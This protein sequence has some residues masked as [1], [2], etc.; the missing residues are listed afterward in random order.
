[1]RVNGNGN[2]NGYHK[3]N[4]S[5][6]HGVVTASEEQQRVDIFD[7]GQ[8]L[9]TESLIRELLVKIGEDPDREGLLKTPKRVDR[10]WEFLTSGY[11]QDLQEVV[12]DAIFDEGADGPVDEM[13]IVKDIE[14]YSLCEHHMIP[15]FGNIHVAYIPNGKV[16]GL[17]KIPR[18][19]EIFARRL[20]VQERITKQVAE[21]VESILDPQGV[22]VVAEAKHMCM[23]MRGIQKQNSWTTTSAMRGV[24]KSDRATR[25]E[26]LDL[27]RR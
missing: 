20:Q 13:V 1:M 25:A 22:A 12:N 27:I 17:S 11:R 8:G 15:F 10:A 6:G 5:N 16:I 9:G 3:K 23:C 19:V 4:G 21:T 24:F 7:E 2:G 18:I 14:F 26:F